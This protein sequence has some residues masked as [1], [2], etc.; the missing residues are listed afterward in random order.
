[1]LLERYRGT[2]GPGA[3]PPRYGHPNTARTSRPRE[4]VTSAAGST[5]G[6]ER[7]KTTSGTG[8]LTRSRPQDSTSNAGRRTGSRAS[9]WPRTRKAPARAGAS[10]Q[11]VAAF[12]HR[13]PYHRGTRLPGDGFGPAAS[14]VFR[15][16]APSRSTGPGAINH[17]AIVDMRPRSAAA[18]RWH[19]LSLGRGLEVVGRLGK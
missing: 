8:H 15:R 11:G 19:G 3:P 12:H 16:R 14:P 6:L 9:H 1:M 2:Q 18:F 5:A 4:V 17:V 7:R 10:L 13:A